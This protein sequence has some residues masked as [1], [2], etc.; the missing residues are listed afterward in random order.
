[1]SIYLQQ[2]GYMIGSKVTHLRNKQ[3]LQP[4][5]EI[6]YSGFHLTQRGF[7]Y[8]ANGRLCCQSD[9]LSALDESLACLCGKLSLL[10]RKAQLAIE[11]LYCIYYLL[12]L[13]HTYQLRLNLTKIET[14][15]S[16]ILSQALEVSIVSQL[17]LFT[18]ASC[19][20]Q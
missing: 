3:I 19:I 2:K 20:S 16:I 6:H 7:V 5:I 13:K 14:M 1:M 17:L 4:P 9:T 10:L 12:T 11:I 15:K 18:I 8:C